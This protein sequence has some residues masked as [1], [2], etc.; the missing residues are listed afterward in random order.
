MNPYESPQQ[1]SGGV[2]DS[3]HSKAIAVYRLRLATILGISLPAIMYAFWVWRSI[4]AI[5]ERLEE[6]KA[7]P[8]LYGAIT[9][10][11]LDILSQG[12]LFAVSIAAGWWLAFPLYQ[13]TCRLIRR[14]FVQR[15]PEDVWCAAS[16]QALWPLPYAAAGGSITWF[17]YE[18]TLPHSTTN[19]VLCGTIGN[20][21][22]AWCYLTLLVSWIKV[23]RKTPKTNQPTT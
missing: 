11:C 1:T 19:D 16:N 2:A 4:V 15:A 22:G 12:V 5:N 7:E 14:I 18:F 17:L 10:R 20:V 8:F 23:A 6:A 9:R 3:A 21:F 13:S